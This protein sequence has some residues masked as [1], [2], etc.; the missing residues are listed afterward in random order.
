MNNDNSS[1]AKV[2]AKPLGAIQESDEDEVDEYLGYLTFST[3][4]EALVPRDWLLNK[5]EE[6]GLPNSLIPKEPSNWSAYRRTISQL[7]EDASV[8]HYQ[9]YSEEL[10]REMK[11]KFHTE[12][13]NEMGS[14]VFILY[15]SVFF[16]EE[17]IGESGGDWRDTRL[18]FFDFQTSENDGFPGQLKFYP[19]IDEDNI[20]YD[21]MMGIDARAGKLFEKLQTH[22]NHS[23]LQKI[24]QELRNRTNAVEI[25]RAVYFMG[26][27]YED[28]VNGMSQLWKDMNQFKEDGE[29]MRIETT[30][31]V[32]LES[33]REMIA[34]RARDMVEDVVDDIVSETLSKFENDDELTAEA[35]SRKILEQ[36]SETHEISNEY[37]ELLSM[38]LS[39]RDIL[40]EQQEE[41][42]EEQEEIVEKVIEQTTLEE[43]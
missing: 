12:K 10:N 3:T 32:N 21:H 6:Y 25:R 24:T 31:V 17:L 26:S 34:D 11:C 41:L 42:K 13:S 28:I 16:P 36:L 35:T 37:N 14:N 8:R 30:P 19:E 43:Q 38:R 7:L 1:Q 5:W 15:T 9:V 4:G 29:E 20:H 18:G 40:E 27:H 22:H 23:D 2:G 33:Q 39:V